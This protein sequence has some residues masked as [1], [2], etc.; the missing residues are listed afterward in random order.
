LT[1]RCHDLGRRSEIRRLRSKEC[2]AAAG[3]RPPARQARRRGRRGGAM[4]AC[5]GANA[6]Q[7]WG[8]PFAAGSSPGR[9]AHARE[10]NRG[11][12]RRRRRCAATHGEQQRRRGSGEAESTTRSTSIQT[13]STKGFLTTRRI[14]GAAPSDRTAAKQRRTGRQCGGLTTAELGLGGGG[15]GHGIGRRGGRR[16]LK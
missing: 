8:A 13:N 7:R 15:S 10:L 12:P 5:G 9:L 6:K 2:A 1:G 11:L 14:Y 16:R 4:P 3:K